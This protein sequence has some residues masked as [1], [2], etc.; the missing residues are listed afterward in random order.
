MGQGFAAVPPGRR[1]VLRRATVPAALVAAPG[2]PAAGDGLVAADIAVEDGR[3]V[4]TAPAG[5]F[6]GG[7]APVFDM[8]RGMVWP[9]LVD[10]HTHLDKGHIWPRRPNPDGTFMGALTSVKAD[11][12]ANW[13]AHDVEA[14]MDFA[15]RCAYAH[16]TVAIRTHIDS[17]DDRTTS[18]WDVFAAMRERWAGRIALEASPLFSIDIA[19]DGEAMER[20]LACV[21]Q[22][23]GILGAVTYPCPELEPGLEVLFRLAGENGWKLDFHVDETLDPNATSLRSIAQAAIRHRFS[24]GILAGH[25]CSLS[26][27]PEGEASRT[28]DL[29]AE[30]GIAVVALPMCNL[31]LQ[32]RAAGRTPT[33]RGVTLLHELAARGVPVMVASDNTRDPFYA[34]G[35]LDLVEVYREATRI[36]HLDHPVGDWPRAVA[37]TSATMMGLPAGTIREGGPADLLLF[38]ARNWSEFLSRPQA[39]RTVLRAGVAIDTALPDYRELDAVLGPG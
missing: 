35:D 21:R 24:A 16:G 10:V 34:Y 2:L 37:A 29:V 26:T 25:C 31:Y 18:S 6:T 7:D 38:R 22:H 5:S 33:R 20:V 19:L 11:R 1:Y 3:I 27:Q 32:S 39:D 23:G 28:M 9:G 14:R 13:T 8:D 17:R 4:A 12:E 15:L 36:A 30:G